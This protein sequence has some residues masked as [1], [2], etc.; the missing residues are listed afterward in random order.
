MKV[1]LT[2]DHFVVRLGWAK[3]SAAGKTFGIQSIWAVGA[4]WLWNFLD[5]SYRLRKSVKIEIVA[6]EL[7]LDFGLNP[8]EER[9]GREKLTRK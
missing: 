4:N 3:L 2:C 8:E 9:E 5:C 6:L 1:N 7:A